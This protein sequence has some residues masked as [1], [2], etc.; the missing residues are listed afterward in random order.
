MRATRA[1]AWR[2]LW[3]W[4]WRLGLLLLLPVAALLAWTSLWPW[5]DEQLL[6]QASSAAEIQEASDESPASGG[7]ILARLPCDECG[8]VEASLEVRPG[9]TL[10]EDVAGGVG[11]PPPA[12]YY[13]LRVRMQDGSY[14]LF[15]ERMPAYWRDGARVIVISGR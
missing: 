6:A 7:D 9:L 8:V 13:L 4:P 2:W 12:G 15:T 14:R 10:A 3:F 11:P 5:P 1:V